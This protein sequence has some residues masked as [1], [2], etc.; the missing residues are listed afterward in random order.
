VAEEYDEYTEEI[1][2]L[3]DDKYSICITQ[4]DYEESLNPRK[5][6]PRNQPNKGALSSAQYRFFVD[7]L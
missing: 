1:H 6:M 7:A 2:L 5:L 3:Q 4:N